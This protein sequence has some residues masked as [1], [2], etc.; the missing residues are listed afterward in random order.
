MDHYCYLC[1]VFVMLSYLY[2][3]LVVT[4]QEMA[5]LLT[6][7]CVMFCCVFVT[8]PRGVMGE[9]WFCLF[10]CFSSQSTAMVM[11]GWSVHLTTL[12]FMGK[13]EHAVN[14]F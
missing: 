4:C 10:Y 12:F 8:F 5:N 2:R 13:L 6:L 9:V 7:L 3:S 11:V 14:Q 1:F